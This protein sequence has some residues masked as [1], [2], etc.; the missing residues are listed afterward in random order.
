MHVSLSQE[1]LFVLILVVRTEC[2]FLSACVP[3]FINP[4]ASSLRTQQW[5]KRSEEWPSEDCQ[6]QT[7][8]L[9][10]VSQNWLLRN[11][12]SW[13]LIVSKDRRCNFSGKLVPVFYHSHSKSCL[14]CLIRIF[15]FSP[16]EWYLNFLVYEMLLT[17]L[18][19]LKPC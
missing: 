14:L 18:Y 16:S 15:C 12:F 13:I 9:S 3:S 5:T 2:E 10:R 6:V 17:I 1:L 4:A 8:A 7:P 19:Y 11:M